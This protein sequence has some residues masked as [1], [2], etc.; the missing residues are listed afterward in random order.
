MAGGKTAYFTVGHK[1]VFVAGP[2]IFTNKTREQHSGAPASFLYEI[3]FPALTPLE[4]LMTATLL[5]LFGF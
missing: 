4:P 2:E 5:K 1:H 3:Y